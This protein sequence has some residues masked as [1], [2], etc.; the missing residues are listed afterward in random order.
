M[1]DKFWCPKCGK[2]CY[3]D[4]GNLDDF[5]LSDVEGCSCPYCDHEWIFDYVLEF[6][7]DKTVE[8]CYIVKGQ[9]KLE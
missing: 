8:D 5:T 2:H 3:V 1:Y 6:E 4:L 7:P 9:K